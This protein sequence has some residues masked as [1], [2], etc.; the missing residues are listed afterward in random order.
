MKTTLEEKLRCV[1]L[2]L[3][4]GVPISEI[5]REYGLNRSTLKHCCA[6]C[7]KW[8]DK[9]FKVDVKRREYPRQKK[10]EAIH[11]I[12]TSGKSYAQKAIELML[13]DPKIIGDWMEKYREGGED[14]ITDTHSREA[15]KHHNDKVFKKEYKKL[16]EDLERTKAEN[17][18]LKKSYS[19]ILKGSKQPR[20]K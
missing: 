1:H 11:D 17:E 7:L 3:Y 13:T 14:A 9:A 12:L 6:L 10:L 2:H 18:Y 20:K 8:G 15:Y 19:L 4:E 16:L 5:E